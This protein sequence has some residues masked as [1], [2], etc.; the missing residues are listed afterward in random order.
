M[1]LIAALLISAPQVAPPIARADSHDDIFWNFL[2][3][4]VETVLGLLGTRLCLPR[5]SW[6]TQKR[7]PGLPRVRLVLEDLRDRSLAGPR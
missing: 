2:Q 4:C 1:K 3:R 6:L 5:R 7:G